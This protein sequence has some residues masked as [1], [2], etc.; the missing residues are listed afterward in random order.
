MA[1]FDFLGF[2]H[3]CDKARKGK[4]KVGRKTARKRFI[5]KLKEL[6]QRMKRVRSAVELKEWWKVLRLK[7]VGHYCYY[8]HKREYAIN[9]GIL[10]PDLKTYPQVDKQAK[11]EEEL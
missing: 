8:G 11:S 5:Q 3:Y 10:Y 6:N 1:T 9:A 2:T 7:M 4:F